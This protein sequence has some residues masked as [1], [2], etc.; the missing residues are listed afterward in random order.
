MGDNIARAGGTIA[1]LDLCEPVIINLLTHG[2]LK[3]YNTLE[4]MPQTYI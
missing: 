2:P 4:E 1:A 3:S